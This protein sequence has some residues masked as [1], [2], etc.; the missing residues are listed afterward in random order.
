MTE[1]A[2]NPTT[3]CPILSVVVVVHSIPRE[4]PRTLFTLSGDY[5][6]GVQESDYEV[7]VVD[8]GS[9]QP[10]TEDFVA[11]FGRNFRLIRTPD[12]PSPVKAV[13]QAASTA[14]GE[15]IVLC[16]DGARLLSPGIMGLMLKAFKAHK[17]PV[18]ATLAWHIGP[19]LQNESMLEGYNQAAEDA[20]LES[21]DWRKDGYELFHISTLAASSKEGW[22]ASPSESNCFGL[23]K[24]DWE[25][26]GGLHEGFQSA[27]GGLVN[28]DVYREACERLGELVILLGE[29]TFHQ[30]HGGVATNV[31]LS[32]HPWPAMHD[33]YKQI[34][35][36]DYAAPS[37]A[38][39]LFG[40]LPEQAV[41][42]LTPTV[43][44]G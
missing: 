24:T 41:K 34:R 18:V 36:R 32:D 4:A 7:I 22:L 14:R 15:V 2:Q 44:A 1:P 31:L 13:N 38:P 29:G 23:R 21:V 43:Q 19:K 40:K 16:I 6:R 17:N 28:L 42:F 37:L 33:E 12:C 11:S 3:H 39:V 20:L 35:G 30:F 25:Q 10:L 5:Q 9:R 8:V 27:G 26:I